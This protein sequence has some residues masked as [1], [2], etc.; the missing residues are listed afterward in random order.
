MIDKVGNRVIVVYKYSEVEEALYY[1]DYYS[2]FYKEEK[3]KFSHEIYIRE[4][5]KSILIFYLFKA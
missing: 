1:L 5:G 2:S 4:R 3:L